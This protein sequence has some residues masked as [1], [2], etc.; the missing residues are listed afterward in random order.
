MVYRRY[1]GFGWVLRCLGSG[2][3]IEIPKLEFGLQW[4][5]EDGYAQLRRHLQHIRV[6]RTTGDPRLHNVWR[7]GMPRSSTLGKVANG[8]RTWGS[9]PRAS[10]RDIT[11][12]LTTL[13]A[14]LR[15]RR[16]SYFRPCLLLVTSTPRLNYPGTD[17]WPF[18]FDM[19]SPNRRRPVCSQ[20]GTFL[21]NE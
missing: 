8:S 7:M 6:W 9:L 19:L 11:A 1:D 4:V 17:V 16:N 21:Q 10:D 3:R 14:S 13:S 2:C 20:N 18:Q 12:I 15:S 5:L